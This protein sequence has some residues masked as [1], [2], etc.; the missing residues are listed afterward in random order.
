MGVPANFSRDG[1]LPQIRLIHPNQIFRLFRSVPRIGTSQ[2]GAGGSKPL[3]S[4]CPHLEPWNL[5]SR[6]WY[7]HTVGYVNKIHPD[8]HRPQTTAITGSFNAASSATHTAPTPPELEATLQMLSSHRTVLGILV[9]S[10][11][12]LPSIIRHSGVVFEGEQG[13]KYAKAVGRIVAACKTGLDEVDGGEGV[14]IPIER[15]NVECSNASVESQDDLKFMR[16]RTK[17]HE[18]MISPGMSVS[19]ACVPNNFD[20]HQQ[21]NGTCLSSCMTQPQS[22]GCLL[23]EGVLI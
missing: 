20:G 22:S 15:R 8:T 17:R 16:I 7:V 18:I 1:A 6:A 3:Q 23:T 13:K 21:M 19:F 10:R 12:T 4:I 11:A 9:L 2:K 14:R 5:P